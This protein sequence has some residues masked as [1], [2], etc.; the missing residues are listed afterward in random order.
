MQIANLSGGEKARLAIARTPKQRRAPAKAPTAC[1]RET[2][3][4][5]GHLKGVVTDLS[6]SHSIPSNGLLKDAMLRYTLATVLETILRPLL[7]HL[8]SQYR[9][10]MAAVRRTADRTR[11]DVGSGANDADPLADVDL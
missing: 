11:A 4:S 10:A 2:T 3:T 1:P 5:N 9:T 7:C 8:P 6:A